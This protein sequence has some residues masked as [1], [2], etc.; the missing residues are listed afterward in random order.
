VFM[1]YRFWSNIV[2]E[3][4]EGPINVLAC[5]DSRQGKVGI[6]NTFFSF[7]FAFHSTDR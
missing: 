7:S 6:M 3:G 1:L 4:G 5:S 2:E